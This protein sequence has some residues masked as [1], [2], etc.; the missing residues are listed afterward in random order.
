MFDYY[1]LPGVKKLEITHCDLGQGGL[2]VDN[3]RSHEHQS[4]TERMLDLNLN[5]YEPASRLTLRVSAEC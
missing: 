1:T 3:I 4:D 5:F 2:T